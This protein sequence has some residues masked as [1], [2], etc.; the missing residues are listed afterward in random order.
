[1]QCYS[2]SCSNG[3]GC[4]SPTCPCRYANGPEAEID[5]QSTVISVE[6]RSPS[7]PSSID[8]LPG[9]PIPKSV[10]DLPKLSL[11]D[12]GA[13]EAPMSN[14]GQITTL[15]SPF[16]S[17]ATTVSAYSFSSSLTSSS[18]LSPMSPF[19][20]A[21]WDLSSP[22]DISNDINI[23]LTHPSITQTVHLPRIYTQFPYIN[24]YQ[25]ESP[26]P[27]SSSPYAQSPVNL[28]TPLSPNWEP[29]L[30]ISVGYFP[31]FES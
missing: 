31:F 30:L 1:M 11:V 6:V 15:H 19:S 7:P 12:E 9:Q 4:Y 29:I 27:Y 3:Y 24:S 28:S 22:I 2:N 10:Y 13:S 25:P 14:I 17:P 23:E 8:T 26:S 16:T 20:S 21:T 18:P 5:D